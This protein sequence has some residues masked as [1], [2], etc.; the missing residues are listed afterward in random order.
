MGKSLESA[1]DHRLAEAELDGRRRR[2][3]MA[4]GGVFDAHLAVHEATSTPIALKPSRDPTPSGSRPGPRRARAP[5]PPSAPGRHNS[6]RKYRGSSPDCSIP[7]DAAYPAA[8]AIEAD[9]SAC[10]SRSD[11]CRRSLRTS[12]GRFAKGAASGRSAPALAALR[13]ANNNSPMLRIMET[14]SVS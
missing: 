4:I 6:S 7:K 5:P 13:K 1:H 11:P 10:S 14:K 2:L 8:T 9:Q 3:A 12:R